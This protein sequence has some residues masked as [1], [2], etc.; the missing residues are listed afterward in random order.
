MRAAWKKKPEAIA[1]KAGRQAGR[2]AGQAGRQAGR[3]AVAWREV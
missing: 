3:V 2:Q 1:C